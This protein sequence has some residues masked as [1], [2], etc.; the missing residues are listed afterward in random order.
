MK[1]HYKLT[2][3]GPVLIRAAQMHPEIIKAKIRMAGE[4]PSSLARALDIS[5]MTVSQVIHCRGTSARV[6]RLISKTT[7]ESLESLWPGR[8]TS[9]ITA[10]R[11]TPVRK[12][13]TA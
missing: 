13:A 1:P 6:A 10:I 3:Q 5:R 12:G 7:G 9:E 11:K 2:A 8:Y 4:T